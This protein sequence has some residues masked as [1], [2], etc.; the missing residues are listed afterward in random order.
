MDLLKTK[1]FLDKLNREFARMSKDPENIVRLDVDIM[2]SYVREL[3]DAVLSEA[4]A[5]KAE[6]PKKQ[7]T[8]HAP[9][10][11]EPEPAPPPPPAPAPPPPPPAPKME[12]MVPEYV[13]PPAP[14]VAP[15]PPPPPPPA[16]APPPAPVAPPAPVV[17][18]VPEPE[19]QPIAPPQN[20]PK[21]SANA[22]GIEQL[23]EEKQA[24]ELSEKLSELP[25][26]DLKKAIALNDRL[27]LTREL[28]AGDGQA[29]ESA[30]GNLNSFSS[31]EQARQFLIDQCIV[32]YAWADKKRLEAAK[33]FIRL[34]RRRYK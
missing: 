11:T 17:V 19:P 31:F 27:L 1:I 23:F 21:P 14:P 28:F 22:P 13:A 8:Q 10:A 29:F 2:A 12:P 16:P 26:P 18:Q 30:I 7:H 4:I 24:K 20:E 6:A 34:V 25:I 3:Y 15:A 33:D 32:R 5:P 9:R